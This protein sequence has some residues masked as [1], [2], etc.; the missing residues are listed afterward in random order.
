MNLEIHIN[1]SL[2]P[3]ARYLGWAP[4]P[5]RIRVTNPAPLLNQ[6]T[7]KLVLSSQST[8]AGGKVQFRLGTTGNFTDTLSVT[9][10]LNGTSLTFYTRG[11]FGSPSKSDGDVK[12]VAGAVP[13]AAFPITGGSVPV[14]VRIRKNANNLSAAERTRFV[15]AFAA[16]NNQGQGSFTDFRMMHRDPLA[17]NQAH[18]APGFLPWHRAYLLDLER[19]LQLIDPSVALPYWR[20]DQPA[21]NIFTQTFLGT[22][23]ALGTVSFA[24]TN[25]LQFWKTDGFTGVN[26]RPSFNVSTQSANVISESATLNLG[27]QYSSF[28][29]MEGNPHGSAHVSFGGMLNSPATAPRDP[30]FFLLHCNVDR[31][32]AKWQRQNARFDSTVV[33][34]FNNNP[35]SPI[36]H[37]LADTMWPWNG[38]TGGTR[39][40]TAPG[41]TLSSSPCV[42]APGASP[43]VEEMLDFQG[44]IAAL[45]RQGFDYDDV[46]F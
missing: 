3:T 28:R 23:D 25:P 45:N 17:L 39:P 38:V 16:L 41:G 46:Q 32:W 12:I 20:F 18:G 6:A 8:L 27:A 33:A 44:K 43:K 24:A 37:R 2:L 42:S 15:A 11:K 14:M 19:E 26:R 29:T 31:L 7:V 22:S 5:C 40:S 10:P 21:P 4:S 1:N 30:L 34:S 36:G 35:A 9:V 13:P